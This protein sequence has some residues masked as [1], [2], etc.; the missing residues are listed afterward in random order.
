M[1]LVPF[2]QKPQSRMSPWLS[3]LNLSVSWSHDV[4]GMRD[5]EMIVGDGYP[6]DVAV[7]CVLVVVDGLNGMVDSSHRIQN[8]RDSACMLEDLSTCSN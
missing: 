5:T 1:L 7:R 8:M 4:S 3:R 6:Y 2:I